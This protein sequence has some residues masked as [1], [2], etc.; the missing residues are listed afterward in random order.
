MPDT[1]VHLS[2]NPRC[3]AEAN[4]PPAKCRGRRLATRE[5]EGRDGIATPN[6]SQSEDHCRRKE[7]QKYRRREER[8]R[9]RAGKSTAAAGR[10]SL[11]E[12]GPPPWLLLSRDRQAAL[13]PHV[14]HGENGEHDE[15]KED[16]GPRFGSS[17]KLSFATASAMAGCRLAVESARTVASSGCGP[18]SQWPTPSPTRTNAVNA[19][20]MPG[21]SH[22]GS[23]ASPQ[24][25]ARGRRPRAGRSR[26]A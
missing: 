17:G 4:V 3:L 16:R 25:P 10:S 8:L 6:E 24:S 20:R 18:P 2:I 19:S 11:P 21:P 13:P 22:P 1:H 15:I 7:P 23:L 14:G 9:A 26:R 5:N 12:L